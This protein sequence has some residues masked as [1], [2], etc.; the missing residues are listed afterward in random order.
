M[1]PF[2]W[3]SP[4][5]IVLCA[6]AGFMVINLGALVFIHNLL[7]A[8]LYNITRWLR[9]LAEKVDETRTNASNLSRDVIRLLDESKERA[10]RAERRIG[11][12]RTKS[13]SAG[14][15][16]G[17]PSCL[18]K[19]ILE[20]GDEF[21]REISDWLAVATTATLARANAEDWQLEREGYD[22]DLPGVRAALALLEFYRTRDDSM[23][24][25]YNRVVRD[26]VKLTVTIPPARA[27][28]VIRACRPQDLLAITGHG[29]MAVPGSPPP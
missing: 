28:A 8:T 20:S 29:I 9:E 13:A 15:A 4:L 27:L 5:V 6:L 7:A 16:R 1:P 18:A 22:D 10:H 26:G 17:L 19:F 2:R 14:P 25:L 11:R 3:D 23:L 24:S 12:L 21:S